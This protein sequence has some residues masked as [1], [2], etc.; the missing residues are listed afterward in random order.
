MSSGAGRWSNPDVVSAA[1]ER[2]E[3]RFAR[4]RG[5][6]ASPASALEG[7]DLVRLRD[8]LSSLG[9]I[10][11]ADE[12]VAAAPEIVCNLGFDRVIVSRVA[13]RIWTPAALHVV[14][15]RAWADEILAIGQA[16]PQPLTPALYE[17]SMVSRRRPITVRD[18]QS[19][20]HAHRAIAEA[21][22]STSYVAAPIM[23]GGAV[24]GFIHADRFFSQRELT[25]IDR[26]TLAI[27]AEAFGFALD[28]AVLRE[29]M[30]GMAAQLQAIGDGTVPSFF[31]GYGSVPP[32]ER[33]GAAIPRAF[34][35]SQVEPEE[36]RITRREADVAR[37]MASGLSNGSIAARLVL[38][39]GTVKSHVKHILRK[40]D[41][42]TRA[43]AVAIWL[44]GAE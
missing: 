43:E 16:N 6:G 38:S 23:P 31:A 14:G 29:H 36:Y 32:S 28:R 22:R 19:Q 33:S 1:L 41:A 4:I 34:V 12:L 42:S 24:I 15:D 44:R 25:D 17:S 9:E 8:A 13:E 7:T 5:H 40:L 35:L 39:E 18:A 3:N 11:R 30:Q 26:D 20:E 37:L 10:A 21:S 27:F 2:S